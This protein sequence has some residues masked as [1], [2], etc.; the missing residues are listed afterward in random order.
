[1]SNCCC[2]QQRAFCLRW[3]CVENHSIKVS[4]GGMLL[5]QDVCRM[6]KSVYSAA[7][8][9]CCCW[10]LSAQSHFPFHGSDTGNS[11]WDEVK[12]LDLG[13]QE[14]QDITD[15]FII[16][17]TDSSS[18]KL[19]C[20]V[21]MSEEILPPVLCPL[22]AAT[23]SSIVFCFT[24]PQTRTQSHKWEWALFEIMHQNNLSSLISAWRSH[25]H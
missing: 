4:L 18:R 17:S 14:T 25:D 19:P 11:G 20:L 6:A 23:V 10:H 16:S 8:F 12:D 13:G 7:A 5:M 3:P 9:C 2:D 1:M 22:K 21:Y 15:S 24:D